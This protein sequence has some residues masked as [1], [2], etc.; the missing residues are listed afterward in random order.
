MQD[1]LR[2]TLNQIDSHKRPADL[3]KIYATLLHFSINMVKRKGN[4]RCSTQIFD[5]L[6]NDSSVGTISRGS[7]QLV[8]KLVE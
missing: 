3:A 8:N 7:F 4:R 2:G 5:V 1:K 6:N